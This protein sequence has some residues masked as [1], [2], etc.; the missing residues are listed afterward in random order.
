MNP[1]MPV[2]VLA[3][4]FVVFRLA[5][6]ACSADAS[7]FV[8]VGDTLLATILGL[9]VLEHVFLAVPVPDAVLWRW[10]TQTKRG[11]PEPAPIP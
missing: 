3:G 1:L 8:V 9:A 7:A 11:L 5:L 4:G 6:A 2:S 10:A